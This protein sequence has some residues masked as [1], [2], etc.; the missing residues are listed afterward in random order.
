MPPAACSS[1]STT[2]CS[3][4]IAPDATFPTLVNLRGAD[5]PAEPG[6]E[7]DRHRGGRPSRPTR[8]TRRTTGRPT[9]A[10]LLNAAKNKI[11]VLFTDR[12]HAEVGERQAE[13]HEPRAGEDGRPAQLRPRGGQAL[14]RQVQARR[15][16][17]PAGRAQVAGL[18]RAEQPGLPEAPVGEDRPALRGGQEAPLR[19]L[20]GPLRPGRG[21]GYVGICTAIWSGV[22]ASHLAKEVVGCGATDPRGNNAARNPR[23]SISPTAFLQDLRNTGSS[24][25]TSTSTR[26]TRTT[27]GRTRRRRTKPKGKQTVTLGNISLLTKLLGKLYGNKKLWITEYGYQTSPPDTA[28]GVTW[29]K[30]AKYLTQAYAI[31]RK[32]P[33]ITMMLWFLLRDEGRARRLAVRPLHRRR[34]EEARV[35]RVPPPATLGTVATPTSQRGGAGSP[36]PLPAT[37]RRSGSSATSGPARR[38]CSRGRSCSSAARRLASITALVCSTSAGSCSALYAALVARELYYGRTPVA[39]GRALAGRDRLAAVPDA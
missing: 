16:R 29:A 30:Q 3:R 8:P 34:Q 14:Q 31:A 13:G 25:A 20:R 9:T 27:A 22:H 1:A 36:P 32:N 19:A 2:R 26:I 10:S 28:F 17:R 37:T 15:R 5:H 4:S 11:Q 18:E 6:L 24:A 33:R 7:P 21:Q 39:L 35:R 23:P 38:F 12:R